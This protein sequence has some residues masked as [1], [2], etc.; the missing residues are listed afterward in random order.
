MTDT[1][2]L[3]EADKVQNFRSV[4]EDVADIAERFSAYCKGG[5]PDLVAMARSASQSDALARLMMQAIAGPPPK[6][7]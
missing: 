2:N 7:K 5:I 6:G 4:L 3:T 1:Q